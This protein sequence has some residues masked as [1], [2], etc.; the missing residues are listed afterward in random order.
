MAL[1][2]KMIT[3][4][5][6]WVDYK[7]LTGQCS[8]QRLSEGRYDLLCT[9]AMTEPEPSSQQRRVEKINGILEA[10]PENGWRSLNDFLVA[11][12]TSN[13]ARIHQQA[14]SSLTYHAGKRFAPEVI[15]DHTFH[16]VH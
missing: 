4:R 7:V 5:F 12:Y 3:N 10:L 1:H 9:L 6:V 15:L 16:M 11:F 8:I 2:Y 14:A 13:D